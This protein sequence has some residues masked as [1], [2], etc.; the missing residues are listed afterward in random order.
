MEQLSMQS[1]DCPPNHPYACEDTWAKLLK[2]I[3][4]P[5]TPGMGFDYG[6]GSCLMHFVDLKTYRE[7]HNPDEDC[8]WTIVES[9][10]WEDDDEETYL[11]I[12]H[13]IH[14]VNALGYMV[15]E[16]KPVMPIYEDILTD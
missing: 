14:Y 16:N 15:T 3:P 6:N 11:Y 12:S 4:N 13:G 1:P 10:G 7:Q 9:E 2:P 8:L 5:Y